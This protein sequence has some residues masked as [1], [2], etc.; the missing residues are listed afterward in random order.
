MLEQVLACV[1]GRT[2]GGAGHA[3]IVRCAHLDPKVSPTLSS[4]VPSLMQP[5][6]QTST[7][8][9]GGEDGRVCLWKL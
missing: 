4:S 1:G 8:V 6:E 2:L 5:V 9:T 3:D 7:I